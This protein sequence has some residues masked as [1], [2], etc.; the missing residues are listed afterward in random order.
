MGVPWLDISRI[1]NGKTSIFFSTE[2]QV[3][4]ES[5]V[6]SFVESVCM[7]NL[8]DEERMSRVLRKSISSMPK[9]PSPPLL[10]RSPTIHFGEVGIFNVSH[11]RNHLHRH[12]FRPVQ[13]LD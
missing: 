2:R 8:L 3:Y 5:R 11:L 1:S 9:P 10:P 12:Y 6:H 4:F 13:V 7:P